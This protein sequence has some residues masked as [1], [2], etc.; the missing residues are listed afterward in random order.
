MPE[1]SFLQVSP[2]EVMVLT[3]KPAEDDRGYILRLIETRGQETRATLSLPCLDIL[4]AYRTNLVEE[5][6]ALLAVGRHTLEVTLT[7]YA[8]ETIRL[9][10]P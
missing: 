6:Q 1:Q 4:H 10:T 8:I 7:P 3:F 5:D 2:P 9:L